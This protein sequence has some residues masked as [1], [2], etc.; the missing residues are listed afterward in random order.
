M[1]ALDAEG[2][3]AA[4]RS[5][6]LLRQAMPRIAFMGDSNT[7]FSRNVSATQY[8]Y[9][10]TGYVHWL[11]RLARGRFYMQ[12]DYVT[13][14][15]AMGTAHFA[16]T[17]AP[18]VIARSPRPNIALV[19]IGT[20]DNGVLTAAQAVANVQAGVQALNAAGILVFLLSIVP[21]ASWNSA[22]KQWAA[23]VNRHYWL[24]AHNPA[25]HV[26]FVDLNPAYVDFSSGSPIAA[27]Q[28]SDG[29]H[30]SPAGGLV[31]AQTI[32]P[33]L[34][35]LLP[36]TS[37]LLP[38][39]SADAW[40][41]T[42]AP[43]GNMVTNGMLS[44][45]AGSLFAPTGS[46]GGASGQVATGWTGGNSATGI[47]DVTCA[48]SKGTHPA[49]PT[50]P[51][52]VMTIGGVG[53]SASGFRILQTLPALPTGLVA[54]DVIYAEMDV[55]W[56]NA[57]NIRQLWLRLGVNDGTTT[58]EACDGGTLVP[59][60]TSALPLPA[61]ASGLMRTPPLVIPPNLA[62]IT[63]RLEG[64]TLTNGVAC[65]MTVSASRAA[66]RKGRIG[67]LSAI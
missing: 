5:A 48:L 19:Q 65:S 6:M 31:K 47:S 22:K 28:Y 7:D 26:R 20:N 1:S 40:D 13:G 57:A 66:L 46:G 11:R 64:T 23:E 50:L 32:L 54:G 27:Y 30:D 62:S 14:L 8:Q 33:A 29:V 59:S 63:V 34:E 3:A 2:M 52:Q 55:S 9:T 61:S 67:A 42:L 25:F 10:T 21:Q 35:P 56:V 45:T 4:V 51:T 41:A 38:M 43:T 60:G 44:G 37:E 15:A 36:P 17:Q 12:P 58:T 18:Q 24:M 49:Y 16:T 53:N 39:T